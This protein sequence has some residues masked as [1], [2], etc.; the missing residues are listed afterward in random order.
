MSLEILQMGETT[1]AE[2]LAV[3]SE[4]TNFNAFECAKFLPVYKT[5]PLRSMTR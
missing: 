5:A 2:V 1:F 4:T 3:K